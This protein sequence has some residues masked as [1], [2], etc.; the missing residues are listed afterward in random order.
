MFSVC[1]GNSL[2]QCIR[3]YGYFFF[4][5]GTKGVALIWFFMFVVLCRCYSFLIN[6]TGNRIQGMVEMDVV[7]NEWVSTCNLNLI[8][9]TMCVF[10]LIYLSHE[11]WCCIIAKE[12]EKRN[13][14]FVEHLITDGIVREGTFLCVNIFVLENWYIFYFS[15]I[16]L[17]YSTRHYHYC[18]KSTILVT[19]TIRI[20]GGAEATFYIIKIRV[21]S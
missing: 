8:L 12:I 17:Y 4:L 6:Y 14:F 19:I 9:Q 16:F 20:W 5:S 7:W 1:L 11:K 3:V 2:Y 10:R 21:C 13:Q 15:E 18:M